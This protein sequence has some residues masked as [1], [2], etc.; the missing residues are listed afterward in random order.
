MEKALKRA[1]QGF[2]LLTCGSDIGAFKER[3]TRAV[4]NLKARKCL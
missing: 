2:Q 1:S 4:R 3:L